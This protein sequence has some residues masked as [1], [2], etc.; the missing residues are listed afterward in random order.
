MEVEF[1]AVE[2]GTRVVLTH[3]GWDALGEKGPEMRE[4]YVDGW[5]FVLGRYGA[6]LDG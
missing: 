4:E 5:D 1:S 3:R 6:T 2:H